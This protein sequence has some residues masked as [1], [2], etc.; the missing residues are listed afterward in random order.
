MIG[1][2]TFVGPMRAER[3]Y[4]NV[5]TRSHETS[6]RPATNDTAWNLDPGDRGAG[7]L[8]SSGATEVTARDQMPR[9]QRQL[10]A[11]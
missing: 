6:G 1:Y 9:H 3:L 4:I 5:Y 7:G 11:W 8:G 2:V 10:G